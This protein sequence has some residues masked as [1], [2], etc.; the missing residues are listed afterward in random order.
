MEA[1]QD[2]ATD[3]LAVGEKTPEEEGGAVSDEVAVK[4]SD[5]YGEAV[6]DEDGVGSPDPERVPAADSVA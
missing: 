2:T 4:D 6:A 1:L 3:A 5:A